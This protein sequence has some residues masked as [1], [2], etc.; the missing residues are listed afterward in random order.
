[1]AAPQHPE[2]TPELAARAATMHGEG[3]APWTIA[4]R[5]GV[6]VG[7]VKRV[8]ARERL[9]EQVE[10]GRLRI[11]QA[12][13]AEMEEFAQ[14]PAQHDRRALIERDREAAA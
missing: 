13:P 2:V 9:R 1:M 6:R 11:R 12:T 14:Q 8:I 5:L 10:S 3:L 4:R 7:D